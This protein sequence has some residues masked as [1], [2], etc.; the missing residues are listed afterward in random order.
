VNQTP[1]IIPDDPARRAALA[2]SVVSRLCGRPIV[3]VGMMGAGKTSIGRR[4]AAALGLSFVDADL[5][6]ESAAAMTVSEI[7][8]THG[9]AYF[10]DG[11]RR[12]IARI[13]SEG[14]AVVATGGGAFMNAS[15]RE[16]IADKGISVWL[17]ADIEVLL[18]RVRKRS[19]RPLLQAQD[20]ELTLRQLAEER[21]PIYALANYCVFSR[22]GP[23]HLIIDAI[24]ETLDRGLTAPVG[25]ANSE[26]LEDV[27][28]AAD[29]EANQITVPVALAERSYDIR[30]GGGLIANIG[31][32]LRR[33]APGTACAIVTDANVAKHWL[34]ELEAALVSLNIRHARIVVD[35]GE[36]SK[37][38]K[39]FTRVCEEIIAARLERN[40][41]VIALGGGVVGDLAGFAAATV[42]RGMRLVQVPTTLLSQ[43][44]SS[45]G[46]KTAINSEHGKNLVGA[47]YQ[48]SLVVIDTSTLASLPQ[49]EFRAGYAEM[50]KYG[51]INDAPFFEWLEKNWEQVFKQG[52]ALTH[53]IATSCRAKAAIVAI[54]ETERGDRA[55]LNLGHTFGHA[56][57][58]LTHF[59][60]SRLIHGEG[61]AIGMACAY[62]F[63][64]KSGHCTKE[65]ATRVEAHL[66]AVG[67]PTRFRD[68][69]GWN[70]GANEILDA[71][72]QDK[73]VE[74][75]ALT[76]VLTRGIG[77]SFIAKAVPHA[78][79][80]NFLREE[81]GY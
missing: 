36:A 27:Q 28:L 53:A 64:A 33:I 54:D 43:V 11:E 25:L 26:P 8:A 40:D 4:L 48:P 29:L 42:R 72:S 20:P 60:G 34:P 57:E 1:S 5:E 31:E 67:L 50:V 23:H 12:V 46:G 45:V 79:V 70:A 24:L 76:F 39:V 68:I 9:E 75:G 30:I 21:Y 74:R 58:T 17:K 65:D 59:N 52:P 16:R 73:K 32:E 78:T 47:F 69:A 55:L 3:L 41:F 22:D 81:L 38:W 62:R 2:A 80:Q 6:I 14:C 44:D 61:V 19:G 71:M 35:P 77:K 13:L 10:R 56:L 49:R 66:R 63:S 37:S 51:L 18:Q 7:F 15:T